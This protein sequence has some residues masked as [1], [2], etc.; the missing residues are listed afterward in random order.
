[1]A[2]VF[3]LFT[4]FHFRSGKNAIVK[5]QQHPNSQRKMVLFK[6]HSPIDEA[7]KLIKFVIQKMFFPVCTYV[8]ILGHTRKLDAPWTDAE[9]R[10]RRRAQEIGLANLFLP[11]VSKLSNLEYAPLAELL[12]QHPLAN[13]ALNCGAP[14]TGNM[15]VLE[16]FGTPEQKEKWLE[17][18]LK[19]EIRSA[20]SMTEPAVASSDPLNLQT[21]IEID[22]ASDSYII[23]G[24]KWWTSGACRPECKLLIV[25]ARLPEHQGTPYC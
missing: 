4:C 12:G 5:F 23:S 10:L 17:P 14:D 2:F 21:K 16:K 19:G 9:V 7:A 8:V 13:E 15:E 18:L 1:M 6:F 20:F 3:S 11:D 22:E 25:L 24:H